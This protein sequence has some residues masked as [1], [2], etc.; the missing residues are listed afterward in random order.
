MCAN[1][2]KF[3]E[4]WNILQIKKKQLIL[5]NFNFNLLKANQIWN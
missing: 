3:G 2:V 1:M 5:I 4:N